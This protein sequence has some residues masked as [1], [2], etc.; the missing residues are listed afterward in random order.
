MHPFSTP[1][2]MRKPYGFLMFSG[3]REYV[4]WEQMGKNIAVLRFLELLYINS[5]AF[6]SFASCKIYWIYYTIPIP[7]SFDSRISHKIA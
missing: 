1:W 2:N 3:I 5:F 6:Y 4:H 7:E